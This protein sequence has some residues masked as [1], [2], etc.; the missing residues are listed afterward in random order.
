MKFTHI[1][2]V[3]LLLGTLDQTAVRAEV[4][5]E[6]IEEKDPSQPADEKRPPPTPKKQKKSQE[7]IAKLKVQK[8]AI[9]EKLQS[10]LVA[11]RAFYIKNKSKYDNYLQRHLAVTNPAPST[12]KQQN[13]NLLISK[14]NAHMLINCD[15]SITQDQIKELSKFKTEA[16][17][18][19]ATRDGYRQ[20]VDIELTQFDITTDSEAGHTLEMT[21]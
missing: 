10:C 14:I 7:E 19:D 12:N 21:Q 4:E 6:E 11:T 20:L 8:K 5:I 2:A 9:R 1:M 15:K 3:L 13:Q 17:K 16:E 18:F